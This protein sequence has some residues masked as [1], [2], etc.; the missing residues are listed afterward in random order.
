MSDSRGTRGHQAACGVLRLVHPEVCRSSGSSQGCSHL[1]SLSAWELG[2]AGTLVARQVGL[3]GVGHLAL[4]W[5]TGSCGSTE[6]VAESG[7]S[8]PP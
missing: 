7:A 4:P 8:A 5:D 3:G 6:A 2:S 1:F